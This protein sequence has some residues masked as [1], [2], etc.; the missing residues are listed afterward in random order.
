MSGSGAGDDL[1]LMV[2]FSFL[3]YWLLGGFFM[4]CASRIKKPAFLCRLIGVL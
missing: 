4:T 3:L 1:L 2:P